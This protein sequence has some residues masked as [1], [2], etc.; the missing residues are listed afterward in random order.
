MN[1][2]DEA[3]TEKLRVMQ[4]Q[5]RDEVA[6]QWLVQQYE[7]RLLYYLHR[8]TKPAEAADLL[9]DVWLRV[10]M[11]LPDLRAPEAFRVWLYKIAHDVAV[12]Q[13]RKKSRREAAAFQRV[14]ETTVSAEPVDDVELLENIE[15]VHRALQELSVP[16]R[17]ILTLRFLEDLELNE[18]ASVISCSL[19]TV[20][21]R[22]HYARAALLKIVKEQC[23]E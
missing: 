2:H 8:F 9:Q 19:G 6:F 16:H 12:N 15:L 14:D 18:I 20:K 17:E 23:G 1:E 21:S 11:K 22:L 10:Y 7:R 5:A 3:L 13:I 4:A